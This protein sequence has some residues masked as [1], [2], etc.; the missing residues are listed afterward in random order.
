MVKNKEDKTKLSNWV[1]NDVFA[2][3][4]ESEK[5][6]EYNERYIILIHSIIEKEGWKTSRTTNNF[7]AKLTKANIL[8]K[9]KDEID[10]L[11]YIK[12]N[13]YGYL[14]ECNRYP[15]ETQNLKPDKY[16]YIYTYLFQIWSPKF[17]IPEDLIYIGNFNIKEPNDEYIPHSQ[18]YGILFELWKNDSDNITDD[19]IKSYK[20]FNLKK[21]TAYSKEIQNENLERQK[22]DLKFYKKLDKLQEE[23]AGSNGKEI[24]KSLGIDIDKEIKKNNSLTYVGK[25]EKDSSKSKKK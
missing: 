24:L 9:T 11:E 4:I 8:P 23:I 19:L 6:P 1:N 14:F 21:N 25:E 5:F 7:R 2:I 10:E 20:W 17:R 13:Y 15:K 22:R 12:T 3:K 18:H 16:N